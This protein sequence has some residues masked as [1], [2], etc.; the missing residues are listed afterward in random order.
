MRNYPSLLKSTLNIN[1]KNWPG[2]TSLVIISFVLDEYI[3][4]I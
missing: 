4:G 3:N 2:C 1:V